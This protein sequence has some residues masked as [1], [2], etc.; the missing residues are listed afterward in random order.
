MRINTTI[1]TRRNKNSPAVSTL[2][3]RLNR[4]SLPSAWTEWALHAASEWKD[5]LDQTSCC[6]CVIF[7]LWLVFS[8][9]FIN[10]F[11]MM[12][13]SAM[14]INKNTFAG[15]PCCEQ[16]PFHSVTM[17]LWK[18]EFLSTLF[19]KVILFWAADGL[20]TNSYINNLLR[21]CKNVIGVVSGGYG[22][23]LTLS[24]TFWCRCSCNY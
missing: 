2:L 18:L 23:G 22:G 3:L 15:L 8:C 1:L 16:N 20:D 7:I 12:S 11:L 21:D 4:A 14:T 5:R 9:C 19:W 13:I 6:C 24:F 17:Q 10:H